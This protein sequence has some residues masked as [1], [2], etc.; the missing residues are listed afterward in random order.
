MAF[1]KFKIESNYRLS[2]IISY[3]FRILCALL[4]V[5]S[6]AMLLGNV[7]TRLLVRGAA[8]LSGHVYQQRR[9]SIEN[10]TGQVLTFT[11]RG[12]GGVTLLLVFTILLGN[13]FASLA[14][15]D[16]NTQLRNP[17]CPLPARNCRKVCT[18]FHRTFY[19]PG[20]DFHQ[21]LSL[22]ITNNILHVS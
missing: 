4:F 3:L 2:D 12:V 17:S 14:R 11:L 8:L 18:F 13:I 16:V 20:N 9:V 5:T 19:R 22:M 1:L 6:G 15:D 7:L 21:Y 10:R